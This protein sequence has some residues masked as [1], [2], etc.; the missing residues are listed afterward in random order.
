MSRGGY[1]TADSFEAAAHRDI[2]EERESGGSAIASAADPEAHRLRVGVAVTVR[3]L[4][5][6]RAD[7]LLQ[8]AHA[9]GVNYE[10][11]SLGVAPHPHRGLWLQ[12]VVATDGCGHAKLCIADH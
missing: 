2:G 4:V 11:S 9:Y 6:A 1:Q 8:T 10:G 12:Y 3:Q 7:L 5:D